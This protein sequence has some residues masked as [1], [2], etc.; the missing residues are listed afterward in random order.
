MKQCNFTVINV[1]LIIIYHIHDRKNNNI[2]IYPDIPTLLNISW[3]NISKKNC[4]LCIF[5]LCLSFL[6]RFSVATHVF[7]KQD[8]V[9]LLMAT[10]QLML[11]HSSLRNNVSTLLIW[12]IIKPADYQSGKLAIWYRHLATDADTNIFRNIVSTS[13]V[14]LCQSQS[15]L[16]VRNQVHS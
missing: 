3:I 11:I 9:A 7:L 13:S 6:F 12:Y 15:K 8:R 14:L 16:F 10:Q 4:Q 5:F 2:L 1:F